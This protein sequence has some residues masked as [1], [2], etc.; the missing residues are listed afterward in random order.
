VSDPDLTVTENRRL[1]REVRDLRARVAAFESS[2]WW[3]L[4]PRFLLRRRNQAEPRS[5][6]PAQPAVEDGTAARFRAEVFDLGDFTEDWFT[7]HIPVWT[8]I[9]ARFEGRAARVLELGSYEGLSAC[10]VLWRLQDAHVTCV[11]TFTGIAGYSPYGIE[12]SGLEQRFDANVG[13]VDS[14]RMRK[15]V[16]RTHAVL[17]RLVE[18]QERYDLVYIDASHT[19]LDVLADA[20]LAWQLLAN[21]GVMI[22]DDYGSI[23]P[24]E[25]PLEHP[26][27][28]I[29]GFLQV[30]AADAGPAGRQLMAVKRDS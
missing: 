8:Q 6:P 15:L 24:G 23:P 2:R 14:S 11:D 5:I 21:R 1:K 18:E 25:D 26:K 3:R 27:T 30:V 19:A 22:F 10:F 7:V 12:A 4:H 16:G 20:A 9:L 17:P 28:G 29:D 13:L